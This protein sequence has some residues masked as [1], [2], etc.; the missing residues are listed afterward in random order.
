M[1]SILFILLFFIKDSQSACSGYSLNK[2]NKP[3]SNQSDDETINFN[4]KSI[5]ILKNFKLLNRIIL[6]QNESA[7]SSKDSISY[8]RLNSKKFKKFKYSSKSSRFLVSKYNYRQKFARRRKRSSTYQSNQSF[9][10]EITDKQREV[11]IALSHKY[12]NDNELTPEQIKFIS[13]F[14]PT[15]EFINFS[16]STSQPPP[17]YV[18]LPPSLRVFFYCVYTLIFFV[19]LIG[20]SLVSL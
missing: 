2:T 8:L 9:N 5:D 7:N 18:E 4:S 12:Q 14:T 11:L 19:G 20:N 16:A 6:R 15:E 13:S 3:L 1:Y 10:K 17:A